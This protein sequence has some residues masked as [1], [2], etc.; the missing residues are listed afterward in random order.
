MAGGALTV[1]PRGG[2]EARSS[3]GHGGWARSVGHLRAL[4]PFPTDM[5]SASIRLAPLALAV[6]SPAALGQVEAPSFDNVPYVHDTGWVAPGGAAG[7]G[8]ELCASFNVDQEGAEW[9]R[10]YFE[11][12]V[13]AGDP[14]AGTGAELRITSMLDGGLQVMNA[15]EVERWERSTAYFNGDSLVVEVWARPGTGTSRVQL[16]AMDMGTPPLLGTTSICGPNDDR[17]PSTDPRSGRLLPVGCTGW[18]IQDCAGCFLTAGH[19]TGNIQVIQFNVP[20]SSSSGSIQNPPPSDQYPVDGASLQSNGGQGVGNDWA[21]FGAFPNGTSGL[22]VT[23]AQGPGFQLSAPPQPGSADIRITGFGTDSTPPER[24][25]TQQTHVGPLVTNSGTTV[26]YQTDTTGGNSGSPVIWEQTDT[27]VGIHTHGGCSSSG[28][29]NSGTSFSHPDLQSALASPQGICGAGLAAAD[30]PTLLPPLQPVMVS[31]QALG[32]VVAGSVTLHERP[33]ASGMFQ[34]IPMT[35]MGGGM[36]TAQ[37]PGYACGDA[38]E[39]FISAQSVTCGQVFAPVGG[40][41]DPIV[42]A[43]GVANTSFADDFETPQGWQTASTATTGDWQRG[44]PVNDPSWAYDPSS[45]GDGS[46]SCFVTQN[47]AGNSDVDN[48]EVQLTSPP[49][50]VAGAASQVD[51]LY[52]LELTN[53]NA[54]DALT[55]EV[56]G[57]GGASWTQLRR[58]DTSTGGGWIADTLTPAELS[59]AGVLPGS[60]M[61]LRFTANDANAQSIVEAGVDG[62][63]VGTVECDPTSIGTVECFPAAAN[64]SGAPGTLRAEGSSAVVDNDVQL[65]AESLPANS[66]GYFLV[67]RDAGLIVSPGGSSGNLCLSG[68]IGRYAGDVLSSGPAGEFLFQLDLTALPQ[69]TGAIGAVAG[70]TFRFQAW[71]RDFTIF[72]TS[73]FT[74]SLAISFD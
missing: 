42:A 40:A 3:K 66:V 21:Y 24:N 51:Y 25:Q 43:V 73:N 6:L 16:E 38:P 69:P 1:V 34:S 19:C 44:V 67:S 68:S 31:A 39:Y 5:N 52:Y 61:L 23:Q 72:P 60:S 47:T 10:L 26:Q 4:S 2:P 46:G 14:L 7:G 63:E 58:H 57:D 11:D 29:Q 65:I 22:T 45:D 62:V 20:P 56:S 48:G 74:H 54:E 32:P 33:S 28:G 55:V 41:S 27:A 12:V 59:G 36:F 35:D 8:L 17:L 13:L 71:F 50:S 18:L 49:L 30:T 64:S 9:I 37:L 15:I 53:Q 70:D